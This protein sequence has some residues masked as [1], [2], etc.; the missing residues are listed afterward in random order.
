V[1]VVEIEHDGIGG[2]RAPAVLAL[3]FGGADHVNSFF[4]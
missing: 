4:V 3:D 2:R 1:A